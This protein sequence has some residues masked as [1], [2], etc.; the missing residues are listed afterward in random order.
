MGSPGSVDHLQ[1]GHV[2]LPIR[3]NTNLFSYNYVIDADITCRASSRVVI[4]LGTVRF[5]VGCPAGA[6]RPAAG[7]V[8]RGLY[9]FPTSRFRLITQPLWCIN[10]RNKVLRSERDRDRLEP[11]RC[12]PKKLLRH[13][14]NLHHLSTRKSFPKLSNFKSIHRLK[15][16]SFFEETGAETGARTCVSGDGICM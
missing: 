9:I 3:F 6:W 10:S 1:S 12:G 4:V 5:S 13:T 14:T 15:F 8:G 11:L 2:S 16:R 7:S